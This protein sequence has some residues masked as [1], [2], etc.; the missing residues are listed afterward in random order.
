MKNSVKYFFMLFLIE[1][2]NHETIQIHNPTKLFSS[3][4]VSVLQLVS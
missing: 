4:H 3:H 2:I 1:Q